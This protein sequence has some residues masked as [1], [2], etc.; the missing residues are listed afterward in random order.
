MSD[1]TTNRNWGL[2]RLCIPA[3]WEGE[4]RGEVTTGGDRGEG[5]LK[6]I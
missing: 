6:L 1:K 2:R 3:V 5:W 4:Q